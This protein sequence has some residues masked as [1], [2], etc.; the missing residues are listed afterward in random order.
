MPSQVVLVTGSDGQGRLGPQPHSPRPAPPSLQP[1]LIWGEQAEAACGSEGAPTAG[2][3]LG[4]V[5]WELLSAGR[6]APASRER[7][8]QGLPQ[9]IKATCRPWPSR[10]WP[11]DSQEVPC[12]S[13]RLH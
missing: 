12:L 4:S 11:R 9:S 3:H 2:L 5:P 6:S 13:E 8:W 10:L 7:L 1:R